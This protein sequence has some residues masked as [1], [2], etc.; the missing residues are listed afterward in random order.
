MYGVCVYA[1]RDPRGD[2]TLLREVCGVFSRSPGGGGRGVIWDPWLLGGGGGTR[3]HGGLRI[4]NGRICSEGDY[5]STARTHERE[6]NVIVLSHTKRREALQ[7]CRTYVGRCLACELIKS[8]RCGVVC[9]YAM[10]ASIH[11]PQTPFAKIDQYD[12]YTAAE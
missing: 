4:F 5:R 11:R 7:V 3:Y 8:R 2:L 6:N 12:S 9:A 10:D 1:V